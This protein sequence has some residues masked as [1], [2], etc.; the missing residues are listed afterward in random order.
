MKKADRIKKVDTI[1][2]R[3][4]QISSIIVDQ[5]NNPFYPAKIQFI[6]GNGTKTNYLDISIAELETIKKLLT[7]I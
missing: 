3:N 4:N 2:Y 6:S 1:V 7:K 5:Y